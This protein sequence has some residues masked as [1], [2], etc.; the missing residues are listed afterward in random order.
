MFLRF[1]L[2]EGSTQYPVA[3]TWYLK[4]MFRKIRELQIRGTLLFKTY[5]RFQPA[6]STRQLPLTLGTEY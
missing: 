3:S 2:S 1:L 5:S 6:L 4:F